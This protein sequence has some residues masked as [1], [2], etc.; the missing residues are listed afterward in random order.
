MKNK[1]KVKLG[2]APN[3]KSAAAQ[4]GVPVEMLSEGK[5][6][7]CPAFALRGSVDKDVWAEWLDGQPEFAKKWKGEGVVPAKSVSDAWR[8]HFDKELR[9]MKVEKEQGKL[10]SRSEMGQ[11]L[12]T[13]A[14][15]QKAIA[16]EHFKDATVL[17]EFCGLMQGLVGEWDAE[18]VVK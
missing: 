9:R 10:I 4:L 5:N 18:R 6:L 14:G 3:M 16:E 17:A 15:K 8:A 13:L 7:G 2:T 11:R 1:P 12:R